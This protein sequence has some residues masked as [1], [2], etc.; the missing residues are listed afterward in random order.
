MLS[1]KASIG[2]FLV[3]I[4]SL[5]EGLYICIVVNLILI[6]TTIDFV[7]SLVRAMAHLSPK[8]H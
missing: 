5:G 6:M 3:G 8:Q 4:F 7:P 1:T 2:I